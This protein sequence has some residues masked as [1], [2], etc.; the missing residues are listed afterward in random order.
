MAHTLITGALNPKERRAAAFA[1]LC[2][3]T[4]AAWL[5]GR[6]AYQDMVK[7]Y[8]GSILGPFWITLSMGVMIA[9][10]GTLYST[11]FHM[12][13][14][15]YLPHVALGII[16]WNFIQ[17]GVGE[18]CQVFIEN[19]AAIRIAR[20]PFTV[21]VCRTVA[22]NFILLAHNLLV[23]LLVLIVFPP[24]VTAAMLLVIPGLLI[25]GAN[26]LWAG[27]ALGL[28]SARFR[29]IPQIVGM[30]MQL[31]FFITPV[32]WTPQLLGDKSWIADINPLYA[33]LELLRAPLLG[34]AP[35]PTCWILALA[36]TAAGWV[37]A[38]ALFARYRARIP[39]WV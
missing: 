32:L 27:M 11:L 7:R 35:T 24:P 14:A 28:L 31:T 34:V 17:T 6:L 36:T 16:G 10:L 25:L 30:I 8:R 1:D 5:W 12:D 20:L 38:A 37:L 15:A 9:A 22:R 2:D 4:S 3:G 33:L 18:G 39:Y 26:A 23:Y 13:I 19:A 21:Y 29:D